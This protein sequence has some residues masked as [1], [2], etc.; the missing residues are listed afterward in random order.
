MKPIKKFEKYE[1]DIENGEIANEYAKL[2]ISTY[3]DKDG[4]GNDTLESVYAEIVKG[5]EI[6]KDQ[7]YIIKQELMECLFDLYK[8]AKNIRPILEIELKK[9]NL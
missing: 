4:Y 3:L 5:D 8:E 1:L 7:A 9:Y 6:E 2:I